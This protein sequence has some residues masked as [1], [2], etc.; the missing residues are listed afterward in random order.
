[1]GFEFLENWTDMMPL[2]G[3]HVIS[4]FGSG[5]KTSLL[6]AWANWYIKQEIPVI[7]TTTVHVGSDQ[8]PDLELVQWSGG[9]EELPA[10]VFIG[11]DESGH[12]VGLSMEQV[13]QLSEAYP[14]H[15]ILV[16]ADGSRSLP[17]KL[18]RSDEPLFPESTTLAVA[19]TGLSAIGG[20]VEDVLHRFGRDGF[21]A[22]EIKTENKAGKKIWGWD[23]TY[24]L[25]TREDGYISKVPADVPMMLAFCQM[26]DCDDTIG[27][28]QFLDRMMEKVPLILM[29]DLADLEP[30]MK[31]VYNTDYES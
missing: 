9:S 1:V 6:E 23:E 3:G 2:S 29:G 20:K 24:E 12:R 21:V 14:E 15:I 16:E 28:F 22:P 7:V 17:M 27:L 8:F 5:G 19:V 4:V 26:D 13:D 31:A 30:R 25:L 11:K 18:H 10:K